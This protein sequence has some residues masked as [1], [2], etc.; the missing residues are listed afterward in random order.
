MQIV[1]KEPPVPKTLDEVIAAGF[2]KSVSSIETLF[3]ESYGPKARAIVYRRK[4]SGDF[5]G[6]SR[7]LYKPN[8]L[9]A[10]NAFS[11]QK[12]ES[13]AAEKQEFEAELKMI[14]SDMRI[15]RNYLGSVELRVIPFRGYDPTGNG[16]VYSYHTDGGGAVLRDRILCCYNTPTTEGLVREFNHA[17]FSFGVGDMWRHVVEDNPY[18]AKPFVHR[19]PQ[20]TS[21][22]APPRLMVTADVGGP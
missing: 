20:E 12:L 5:N 10:S 19:A 18:G 13:I 17:S 2:V 8:F 6:L 14:L 9:G 1:L 11:F 22:D 21:I 15:M 16:N 4:L 7:S 3:S